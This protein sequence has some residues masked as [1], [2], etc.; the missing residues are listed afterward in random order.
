MCDRVTVAT[1]SLVHSNDDRH[2]DHSDHAIGTVRLNVLCSPHHD[3][4]TLKRVQAQVSWCKHHSPF[5]TILP[6]SCCGLRLLL[7]V[8]SS[9]ASVHYRSK[10]QLEHPGTQTHTHPTHS[11]G[12]HTSQF[13]LPSHSTSLVSK[14]GVLSCVVVIGCGFYNH[15][16]DNH[17]PF[18]SSFARV[19]KF[20]L[21][22]LAINS[23][24]SHSSFVTVQYCKHRVQSLYCIFCALDCALELCIFM[25][26][27]W[28]QTTIWSPLL[29]DHSCISSLCM[30][31]DVLFRR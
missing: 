27:C 20:T 10:N 4:D 30:L 22:A 2:S 31:A 6:L 24:V 8:V 11:C 26:V 23:V 12:V 25:H 9:C 1:R 3:A 5:A 16:G 14:G 13:P 17:L 19:S 21:F 29:V 7:L 18:F 15:C 28:R